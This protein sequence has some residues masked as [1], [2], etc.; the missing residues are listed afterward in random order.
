MTLTSALESRYHRASPAS[1][2]S[3]VK[4][5]TGHGWSFFVAELAAVLK[6]ASSLSSFHSL[7]AQ[8][9]L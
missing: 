6:P 8:R 9:A 1:C 5:V 3:D 7:V 2:D 4:L